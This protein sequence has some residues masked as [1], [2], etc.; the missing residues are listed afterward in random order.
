M[1]GQYQEDVIGVPFSGVAHKNGSVVVSV[2]PSKGERQQTGETVD[3]SVSSV[4]SKLAG[5]FDD[6]G[7]Y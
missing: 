7:Y 3:P 2:V 1:A 4:Y 5:R 6:K